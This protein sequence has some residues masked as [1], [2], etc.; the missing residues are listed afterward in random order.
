VLLQKCEEVFT[1]SGV[2]LFD[3]KDSLEYIGIAFF[4]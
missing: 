2:F 4:K 3:V 1:D